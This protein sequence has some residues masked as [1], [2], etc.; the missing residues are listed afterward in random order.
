[1]IIYCQTLNLCA[2]L[3]A[4]FHFELRDSS[5]YPPGVAQVSDNRLFGMFHSNTTQYNKD[6]ILKSLTIR[7]GVVKIVFTTVALGMWV[8]LV[9]CNT[10]V[11]YGAPHSTDG[12]FQESGRVGQSGHRAQSTVFWKPRDCPSKADPSTVRDKEMVAVRQYLDNTSE[13]CQKW[14]L[15]YF[16]QTCAKHGENPSICCDICGLGTKL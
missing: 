14:L 12:Y 3:Y 16:D 5:Y 7:D 1:M 4:H 9:D 8:N 6:I 10:V 15:N 13:C 2:D 11:H